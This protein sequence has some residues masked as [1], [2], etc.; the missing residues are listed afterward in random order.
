M[1][2][3]SPRNA[4][5]LPD[6]SP[7]SSPTS[8]GTPNKRELPPPSPMISRVWGQSL[9]ERMDD[10]RDRATAPILDIDNPWNRGSPDLDVQLLVLESEKTLSIE[11]DVTA[12]GGPSLEANI[13]R[14][15]GTNTSSSIILTPSAPVGDERRSLTFDPFRDVDDA[16]PNKAS[17]R[18]S[19][20][21]SPS[22]ASPTSNTYLKVPL[23]SSPCHS[24]SPSHPT[25]IKFT[26][27]GSPTGSSLLSYS[28]EVHSP[29]GL[30]PLPDISPL[31]TT[32][33]NAPFSNIPDP[34]DYYPG[35]PQLAANSRL[36]SSPSVALLT[37]AVALTDPSTSQGLQVD[38]LALPLPDS[39]TVS[40]LAS[41]SHGALG[42]GVSPLLAPAVDRGRVWASHEYRCHTGAAHDLTIILEE[43]GVATPAAKVAQSGDQATSLDH[44]HVGHDSIKHDEYDADAST[45]AD[46]DVSMPNAP[47]HVNSASRNTY[48]R[49]NTALY[50]QGL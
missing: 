2:T 31:I 40:E 48:C 3:P 18:P 19:W 29:V 25:S 33:V 14:H 6:I 45:N 4:Q 15:N 46:E 41:P 28:P 20:G 16:A 17:K 50:A 38:I 21:S 27:V 42:M 23:P 47:V 1:N 22:S 39:P 11:N 37:S 43:H 44:D 8:K 13:G 34:R 10:P 30:A 5:E 49:T 12:A 24:R 32:P 26:S 35:T 36:P 7:A 9:D